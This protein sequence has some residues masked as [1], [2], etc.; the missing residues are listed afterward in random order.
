MNDCEKVRK[1]GDILTEVITLLLYFQEPKLRASLMTAIDARDVE[2]TRRLLS[3]GAEIVTIDKWTVLTDKRQVLSC[4]LQLAVDKRDAAIVKVLLEAGAN[5]DRH[6]IKHGCRRYPVSAE[7]IADAVRN[8]DE[9]IVR[10]LLEAG[11][12]ISELHRDGIR[13]PVEWAVWK[14]PHF[15]N[16]FVE[17]G[18]D[19]NKVDTRTGTNLTSVLGDRVRPNR[20]CVVERLV[21][22]GADVN[23]TTPRH[24][25]SPLQMA[26]AVG[27]PREIVELLL[28]KGADPHCKD[29]K[30]RNALFWATTSNDLWALGRLLQENVDLVSKTNQRHK[31]RTVFGYLCRKFY[32]SFAFKNYRWKEHLYYLRAINLL[33][34]AGAKLSSDKH[35]KLVEALQW[36]REQAHMTYKEPLPRGMEEIHNHLETLLWKCSNVEDLAPPLSVAYKIN[37]EIQLQGKAPNASFYREF[38]M[39]IS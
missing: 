7:I 32:K 21:A 25:I 5:P 9:D 34:E 13:G 4:P 11:V 36:F 17:Y 3:N 19:I 33:M 20:Y 18:A 15:L 16:I 12:Y 31:Q 2:E 10:Y 26:I 28:M 6:Y 30:G 14:N 37:I 27:G 35:T 8:G 23:L 38:Y 24:G 1:R 39:T 22:L 29:H